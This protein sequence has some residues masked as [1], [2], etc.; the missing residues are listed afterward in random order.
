[1]G[2]FLTASGGEREEYAFIYPH[3][4]TAAVAMLFHLRRV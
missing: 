3:V 4:A 2:G 1:M